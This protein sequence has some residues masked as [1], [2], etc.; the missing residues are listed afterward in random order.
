M[1]QTTLQR[2]RAGLKV[3]P[4][5]IGCLF[6]GAGAGAW[7]QAGSKPAS[8]QT[9]EANARVLQQLPFAD[10][11]DYDAATRGLVAPFDEKI[12][13]ANGHAVRIPQSYEFLKAATSPDTVN[14][15]LWRMAQLNA[16][17]GLYRVVERVYQVR[18]L[19]L[20]N[21]TIVEGDTGLIVIDPLLVTETAR[22]A[23]DLYHR[24]RPRKPVVA[25][26]YTHS[27]ADHFGGVRGV[28]DEADV[29]SGKVQV[30]GPAGFMEEA[31]SENVFAGTAMFRRGVYQAGASVQP[32]A[33]GVV[34][35]GIG[36]T[37]AGAGTISL[38]APTVTI[39]K[40]LEL[41]RIDGVDIEFQQTPG[42]EAPAEMNLYLPQWRVLDVAENATQTMHNLLTP[43][44]A[45]VRDARAWSRYL[46]ECLVRYGDRADVLLAQHNW[47][48]W[49]AE[50]IRTLLADQRDMYAYL[51]NQ[52]LHLINQGYAPLDIAEAM[53][54]LPGEL[55][56]K[57]YTRGYYG[58]LSF[59][60]RAVYQR[61]MGFY[62][63]NPASLAPLAPV[64]AARRYVEAMGGQAAVVRLVRAAIGK[65][66]YRWAAQLGNHA[67]LAQPQDRPA[68]EA[69]ADALEQLA[70]QSENALWRNMYLSA[71]QELREGVQPPLRRSSADLVRA[72]TPGMF[73]DFM[74]VRVQADKAQ[75]HDMTLDWVF[76]DL[77]KSFAITLRNGVLTYRENSRH[78]AADATVT[79]SKPT[80]DRI[81]LRQ[82]D[83]ASAVARGEVRIEGN[84][85]RLPELMGLLASFDPGFAIVTPRQAP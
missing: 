16:N 4:L 57:W 71:V 15:S 17:A 45:L 49:G 24:H 68:R 81:S 47:P 51:N 20:A 41:R 7:A 34:D 54:A 56:R 6:A 55:A 78:P 73:F 40:P 70:Y 21:M 58:S 35:T 61:Y 53:K 33:R 76:P 83:L 69:Q 46:D 64:D 82:V 1:R 22:A 28:V 36:K 2:A 59:N 37:G 3:A 85:A 48:T 80:L 31:A 50:N 32:G 30:I 13:D 77:G 39:E 25:V 74:A 11:A 8:A 65:G 26:I 84:A 52:T 38:I 42:T 66:E 9:V 27:H 62:D 60:V 12:L 19:D 75:G 14:P 29:K 63:G 79:M 10:R 23:L 43:R 72:L 5:V 44:G 18:G 67:V